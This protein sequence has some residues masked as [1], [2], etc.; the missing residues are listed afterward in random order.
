MLSYF[1]FRIAF[2]VVFQTYLATFRVAPKSIQKNIPDPQKKL[3]IFNK[4]IFEW[5]L[6]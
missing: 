6:K 5:P 4:K 1:Q 3:L 2:K